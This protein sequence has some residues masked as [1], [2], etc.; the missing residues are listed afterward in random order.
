MIKV[1]VKI[2]QVYLLKYFQPS[3]VILKEKIWDIIVFK[4][5]IDNLV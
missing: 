3:L 1:C 4:V 5:S 2:V